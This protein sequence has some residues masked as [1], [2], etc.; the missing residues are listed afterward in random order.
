VEVCRRKNR[1]EIPADLQADYFAALAQLPNLVAAAAVRDWDAG[2]LCC[3]LS[4]IAAAKGQTAVAEAVL[5]LTPEVAK[6]FMDW[7]YER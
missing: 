6:Q 2:F 5:E 3:T 1:V 4:A 7:F